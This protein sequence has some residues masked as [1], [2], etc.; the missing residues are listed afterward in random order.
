LQIALDPAPQLLCELA[1]AVVGHL[2][3]DTI[4]RISRPAWIA[5]GL[6]HPVERERQLLEAARRWM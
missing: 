2:L 4:T 1:G 6:L 3:R 5:K